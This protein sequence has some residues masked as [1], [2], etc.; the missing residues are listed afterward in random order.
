[1]FLWDTL[2]ACNL[3]FEKYSHLINC[4][5]FR[6]V[7]KFQVYNTENIQNFPYFPQSVKIVVILVTVVIVKFK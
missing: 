6:R 4:Q 3:P 2:L 7:V 5:M 1:M